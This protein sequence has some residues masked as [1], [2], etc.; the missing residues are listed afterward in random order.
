MGCLPE[1]LGSIVVSA[2][3]ARGQ[4]GNLIECS[5]STTH[6]RGAVGSDPSKYCLL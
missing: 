3:E 1:A 5:K 6:S 2:E 4:V